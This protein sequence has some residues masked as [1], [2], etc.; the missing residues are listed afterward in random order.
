M[1]RYVAEVFTLA[2]LAVVVNC[3]PQCLDFRPPFEAESPLQF[4]SNYTDFGCC[5]VADDH[6]LHRTYSILRGTLS[7]PD[8]YRCHGYIRELLCL[9]CSPYAAHVFDAERTMQA[10]TFPGL[11]T[12]YCLEFFEA[13]HDVIQFLDPSLAGSRLLMYGHVFCQHV[14]LT[15][16]DYCYPDL[17]TRCSFVCFYFDLFNLHT[18]TKCNVCLVCCSVCV[19]LTDC[20]LNEAGPVNILSICKGCQKA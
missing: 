20:A 12:G 6:N 3:H 18:T 1:A 2:F 19:K 15:D 11:C 5:T 9:S 7:A 17:L 13:C 16:V 4:C 14:A 10:R 8:W